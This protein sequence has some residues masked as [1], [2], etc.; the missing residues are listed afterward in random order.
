[1]VRLCENKV[2]LFV[3]DRIHLWSAY[4]GPGGIGGGYEIAL[5]KYTYEGFR[6]W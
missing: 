4:V 5:E 2:G 6:I 3:D 1:M